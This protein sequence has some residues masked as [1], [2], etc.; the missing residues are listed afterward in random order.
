[1][2]TVDKEGMSSV[3][4][5]ATVDSQGIITIREDRLKAPYLFWEAETNDLASPSLLFDPSSPSLDFLQRRR[6]PLY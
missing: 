1:M 3:E 4:W 2:I 5:K 6:H